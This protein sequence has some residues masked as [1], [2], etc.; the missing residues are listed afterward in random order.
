[1]SVYLF[2]K[3]TSGLHLGPGLPGTS[4]RHGRTCIDFQ[5]APHKR[6]STPDGGFATLDEA[7]PGFDRMMSWVNGPGCPHIDVLTEEEYNV[8]MLVANAAM[9]EDT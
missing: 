2:C 3:E 4:D 5:P 9:R 6:G 8:A 1:M 7:E